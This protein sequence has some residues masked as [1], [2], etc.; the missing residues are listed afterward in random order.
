[1]A[2]ESVRALRIVEVVLRAG[3]GVVLGVGANAEELADRSARER[4]EARV[5][6]RRLAATRSLEGRKCIGAF[7]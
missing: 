5:E 6:V 1:M 2:D 7:G 4:G 3:V